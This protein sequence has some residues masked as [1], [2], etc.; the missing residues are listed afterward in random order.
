MLGLHSDLCRWAVKQNKFTWTHLDRM[1]F[2]ETHIKGLCSMADKAYRRFYRI[3]T[4]YLVKVDFGIF[5]MMK[6]HFFLD[7]LKVMLNYCVCYV[8]L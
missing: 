2:Y 7:R 1:Q 8:L 6:P 5:R 3:F 4:A